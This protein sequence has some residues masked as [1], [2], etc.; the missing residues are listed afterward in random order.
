MPLIREYRIILPLKLEEYHVGQLYGVAKISKQETGGGLGVE[1][2]ENKPY[3]RGNE[4]GQYTHKIYHIG[5]RAPGWIQAIVPTD[6]LKLEE[7][8]WNAY[9]VCGTYLTNMWATSFKISAETIH[10][11]DRGEQENIHNLP[12]EKLRQRQVVMIDIAN[13]YISPKKYKTEEDPKLFRSKKT[14]R[15]LLGPDWIKTCEPVMCCY[16][17]ITVEFP[18]PLIG[19][20]IEKYVHDYYQEL[21]LVAHRQIFCSLDEWV[22]LTMDDIRKLEDKIS[23]ELHQ[24]FTAQGLPKTTNNTNGTTETM[25][26][27]T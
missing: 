14:G 7:K 27:T 4:S 3:T 1:V 15:G 9:P 24:E 13:D 26:A 17:L 19:G 12:P 10:A 20:S 22:D 21:N 25:A 8:A 6:A 2:K 18:K 16:K 23:D 5:N 11:A